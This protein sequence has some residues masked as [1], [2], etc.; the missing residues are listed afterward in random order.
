MSTKASNVTILTS[1][2]DWPN[3]RISVTSKCAA[4]ECFSALDPFPDKPLASITSAETKAMEEKQATVTPSTRLKAYGLLMSLIDMSLNPLIGTETDPRKIVQL[5]YD[6]F[7]LKTG[8]NLIALSS[9]FNRLAMEPGESV[10]QFAGRL[11]DIS[12]NMEALGAPLHDHQIIARFLD[13]LMDTHPKWEIFQ[14]IM[15]AKECQ[16]DKQTYAEIKQGA[17]AYETTFVRRGPDS[18]KQVLFSSTNANSKPTCERCHNVGHTAAVCWADCVKR[19]GGRPPRKDSKH[20]PK[21]G[22]PSP[23]DCG[24]MHWRSDCPQKNPKNPVLIAQQPLTTF[25]LDTGA[26]CHVVNDHELLVDPRPTNT[27]VTGIGGHKSA[28]TAIG[29][30]KNFPGAC[31]FVPTSGENIISIRQLTNNGWKATFADG[32]ALLTS[33]EG[34]KI[35]GTLQNGDLYRIDETCYIATDTERSAADMYHWHCTFGHIQDPARLRKTVSKYNIKTSAWPAEMPHCTAC[36][37]GTSKRAPV[38]HKTSYDNHRS[39]NYRPGQ[40]LNADIIGP[41]DSGEYAFDVV[42][43]A[44]RYEMVQFI[45]NKSKAAPAM[46]KLIDT[47]YTNGELCDPEEFHTDRAKEFL[48]QDWKDLCNERRVRATYTA[49]YTPEHNGIAERTHATSINMARSMLS[50]AKLDPTKFGLQAYQHAVFL[51]NISTTRTLDNGK[52]PYESWYGTSPRVDNL[53][54]FGTRVLYHTKAKS[55]FG[56]RAAPG[57]YMGPAPNTTGSAIRVHSLETGHEITT[58]SYKIDKP[59]LQPVLPKT[60]TPW[61]SD[62]DSS[63][64]DDEGIDTDAPPPPPPAITPA[65]ATAPTPAAPTIAK[66][67]NREVRALSQIAAA[68]FDVPVQ[69]RTRTSART[70]QGESVSGQVLLALSDPSSPQT[71]KQAMSRQDAPDWTTALQGELIPLFNKNVFDITPMD[72][73]PAHHRPIR[74]RWVLTTKTDDTTIRRKARLVACGY[75]Q[76]HGVDF[77]DVSAPVVNKE[78]MRTLFAIAAQQGLYML[79]YD[80]EK[81]YINADLD[82]DIYMYAPDGF[83]DILGENL[84]PEQHDLITNK[85]AVLKLNKALYGLKQSGL[86][87]FNELRTFF[88]SIGYAPTETD[89]CVFFDGQGNFTFVHVDDG[90]I[91]AT[92]EAKALSFISQL[93]QRYSVK[94]LGPPNNSTVVGFNVNRLSDGSIFLHQFNY[95][96]QMGATYAP[97]PHSSKVT[98]MVMGAALNSDSPPGDKHLYA[99]MIGTLLFAAVCTR[100]D[101]SCAVS[102]ESRYMQEPTKSHLSLARNTISYTSATANYG[103][104]YKPSAHL[105]VDV[106]CDASFA[107][108]EENRKSRSGWLVRV[109]GT[110]VSWKSGLQPIIAHSTAEAEYIS[111]SD[112]VREAMAITRLIS[113][114]GYTTSGPV[115]V[116]EDNITAMTIAKEIS[117]K[118]SKHIELRY[119]HIR[120]LVT[121]GDIAIVYCPTSEQLADALTKALPKVTFCRLRDGFM[122]KGEC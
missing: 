49:G 96:K 28:V 112:S 44:T 120:Q 58:R 109:N 31:N 38:S 50:A 35:I 97:D 100:P 122:S 94:C 4:K 92:S 108:E 99:E 8:S 30:L 121:S 107:P 19:P 51:R 104:L 14:Q 84:S 33:T 79:Q 88:I 36:I 80:F 91:F 118:R 113:E 119:H 75:S 56:K 87:W 47:H 78:S 25:V 10:A 48:G 93:Q 22:P 29:S 66:S 82:T 89:P 37:E 105:K 24:E 9:K 26:T 5:L 106:Y 53:L 20:Q 45:S 3:W 43:E 116:H 15:D 2:K 98:P 77:F 101:I 103:L 55:K 11:E 21:R 62:S 95:N 83:A 85:K 70:S 114:L 110:P 39:S 117:T 67:S 42:D 57:L 69:G 27:Y 32:N 102:M 7:F 73:I 54:P 17:K 74:S 60:T 86:L 71:F 61:D 65:I 64:D 52:T 81:A 59:G 1:A 41:L 111:M 16:G 63:D 40:R 68:G 12:N 115:T 23:C 34:R 6:H 18:N 13:G 72:K 46:A 90:L 76:I